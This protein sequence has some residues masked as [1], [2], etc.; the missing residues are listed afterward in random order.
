MVVIIFKLKSLGG[1]KSRQILDFWL[2]IDI[3]FIFLLYVS[4]LIHISYQLKVKL[5]GSY[6]IPIP[7]ELTRALLGLWI[8]HRLLGGGA[9]KRRP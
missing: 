2:K 4:I 9:F 7:F 5:K 8:F 6:F 1:A 3:R